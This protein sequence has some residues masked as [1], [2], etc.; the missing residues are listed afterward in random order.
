MRWTLVI[1]FL[2]SCLFAKQIPGC[3]DLDV[4]E[5]ELSLTPDALNN[6]LLCFCKVF[7]SNLDLSR[8]DG[9][10]EPPTSLFTSVP[11]LKTLKLSGCSIPKLERGEFSSL[12][13]LEQLDLRVNLIE[14]ISAYAFDGLSNLKRLSLAGNYIS[15]HHIKIPK[16]LL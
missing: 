6:L 5:N 4:L 7:A 12:K 1:L 11:E 8:A 9:V 3:P 10:F 2:A 13:N 14:N 15:I 16:I